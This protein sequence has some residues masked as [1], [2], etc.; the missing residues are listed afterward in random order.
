MSISQ[1]WISRRVIG[2]SSRFSARAL[3]SR[4]DGRIRHRPA[5]RRLPARRAARPRRH[6]RRLPGAEHVHLGRAVA[7][8]LLAPELAR[9][10][11]LPRALPARVAA[12]GDARP[13]EHRAGLRRGRGRRRALHR[14][15]LRRGHGPRGAARQRGPLGAAS[16]RSRCS[17]RSAAALDAAHARGLVHRD[18]KPANV[19]IEGRRA[20]YLTDFGLTKPTR[21]RDRADRDRASSSA[22]STTSRRSR[23]RRARS[24]AAPTSTRSA[25]CCSSAS[26]GSRAVPARLAGGGALRAPARAPAARRARCGPSCR[27][28]S[29]P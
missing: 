13:P 2:A 4:R 21:R 20:C 18:V 12:R 10:D 3:V 1:E 15:A 27:R 7:L 11:G 14:D 9:D 29:T 26:P 25:A 23:S 22:R 6:G 19:L 28:R 16:A 17:R 8:K 5:L 24:T